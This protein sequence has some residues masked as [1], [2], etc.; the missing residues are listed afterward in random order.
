MTDQNPTLH[1]MCGKIAAGKSTL[2]ATLAKPADTVLIAEDEWL[3]A[4]FSEEMSTPKDYFLCASRLRAIMGPHVASLLSAGLSV[5]LDFQ[6]NTV[7]SR[8]WMRGIIERTGADHR[9]H[10]LV[11][12]DEVCLARLRDRNASGAHPFSVTEAQFHQIARH[13]AAPTPEE[14]FNLVIHDEAT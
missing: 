12:P 8:Q 4:L 7:E 5:V 14:G 11:P 6:A 1:M 2:A 13:F 3:A 10:V 9:L